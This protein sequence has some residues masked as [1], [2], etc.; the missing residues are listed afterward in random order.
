MAD[1]LKLRLS[2]TRDHPVRGCSGQ[3]ASAQDTAHTRDATRRR[4]G[5]S[6][7]TRATHKSLSRHTVGGGFA[8]DAAQ[9]HYATVACESVRI[10]A[11]RV[12]WWPQPLR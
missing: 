1:R 7:A 5:N 3:V 6:C 2:S 12:P 10:A 11:R 4:G 9:R 8:H